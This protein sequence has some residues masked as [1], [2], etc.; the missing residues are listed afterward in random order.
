MP[1][2]LEP[3]AAKA[4]ERNAGRYACAGAAV[5]IES[6]SEHAFEVVAPHADH[7]AWMTMVADALGTRSEATTRVFL[8]L[9]VMLCR[10]HRLRTG[11][12]DER[13][14][15]MTVYAPDEAEL[16]ML[17]QMVGGI[18]PRNEVEAALAAQMVAVFL[19]QMKASAAALQGLSIDTRTA[20]IAGK[21]ARTYAMLMDTLNRVRGKGRSTKQKIDVTHEKHIHH[22]RHLHVEGGAAELGGQACE[23][24]KTDLEGRR[25]SAPR[26]H[27]GSPSLPSPHAAGVVVP[28]S[29]KQGKE[30]MSLARGCGGVGSA[31][32]IC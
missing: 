9:L 27:S 31:K 25:R 26:E 11:E 10:Q 32:R 5:E 16:N 3:A 8:N 2:F 28:M 14:N 22:H 17:L 4:R 6:S 13:G 12:T 15:A 23:P 7:E 30:P 20:A 24:S 1:A 21:L 19:M 18:R 29:G